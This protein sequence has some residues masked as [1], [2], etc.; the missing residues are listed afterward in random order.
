[1]A[2]IADLGM[3]KVIGAD[4]QRHTLAPGTQVFM[5]PEALSDESLHGFPIDVFSLG[6][7]CVAIHF[8]SMQ[9]LTPRAI[10][11]QDKV[12]GKMIVL[13]EQQ[14]REKYFVNFEQLSCSI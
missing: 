8:V 9:W 2:K 14:Q 4:S 7:T 5:P 11:Q 3:A 6:C 1:M 12:T 10:K 13:T